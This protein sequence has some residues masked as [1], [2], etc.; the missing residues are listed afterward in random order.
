MN[1]A[2]QLHRF[3]DSLDRRYRPTIRR[4]RRAEAW[5]IGLLDG[6]VSL[7]SDRLY[8]RRAI[9]PAIIGSGARQILF[10]GVRGY[11]R[12]VV[13]AMGRHGLEVWTSDIDPEAAPHG[14]P[15]RHRTGDVC[16]IDALFPEVRFDLVILNGVLGWGV[17]SPEDIERA[18]EGVM[19]ILRPGGVLLL[20]WN[21]GRI[22]DP[23][24]IPALMTRFEP[25]SFESLP[26]RKDFPGATH[27]YAWYGRRG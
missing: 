5:W 15:A 23:P 20:G 13:D 7:Q 24:T 2:R 22:P 1:L 17:D 27:L 12:A 10:I 8:L 16:E 18:L 14:A 9:V 19:R 21:R 26:Q 11:T 3:V 6:V 25:C 4:S